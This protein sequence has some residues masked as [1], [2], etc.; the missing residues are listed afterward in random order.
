M[1][2]ECSTNMEPEKCIWDI[3]RKV[4]RKETTGKIETQV[5]ELY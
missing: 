3:G 1:G 5:G 2:R 4:R